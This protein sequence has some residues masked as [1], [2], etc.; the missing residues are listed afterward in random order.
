MLQT[1]KRRWATLLFGIYAT[2]Q[3]F[4]G[5]TSA[6]DSVGLTVASRVNAVKGQ[7]ATLSASYK[8]KRRLVTLMWGKVDGLPGGRERTVYMYSPGLGL[9]YALGPLEGRAELVGEASLKIR[10][11]KLSDEGAYYVSVI[12]DELGEER[13]YVN[14]NVLVQPKV[15]VGPANPY[16]VEWSKNVTLTCSTKDAKPPIKTLFWEKDG[17]RI[18]TTD[19]GK[20][21]RGNM[22]APFLIISNV[23]KNEAGRY[24]CV[25]DH[26]TGMHRAELMLKVIY[27][28]VITNITK[29]VTGDRISLHCFA[30]GNP[31]PE[32]T[33][34]KAKSYVPLDSRH[35]PDDD[36]ATHVLVNV[37]AND[38]GVYICTARNGYGVGE[39][40]SLRIVVAD[41][42]QKPWKHSPHVAIIAGVAAAVAW[43]IVCTVLVTCIVHRRRKRNT[44]AVPRYA[45]QLSYLEGKRKGASEH[46]RRYARVLYDYDPKDD[47]E[48]R[49]RSNDIIDIIRGDNEGWWF[50]YLNGRCGLFPSNYVE[51]ITVTEREAL[52]LGVPDIAISGC[53]EEVRASIRDKAN[54]EYYRSLPRRP[55]ERTEKPVCPAHPNRSRARGAPRHSGLSKC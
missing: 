13:K 27:P 5:L 15:S 46:E 33:W 26:V 38:S 14:L 30:D 22:R 21:S 4:I 6:Q 48:L 8:S 3:G 41:E 37:M 42:V 24:A 28:A 18:Q 45:L 34:T 50:G 51:V 40:R 54:K 39:S 12:L 29:S 47:D 36:M 44:A 52:R 10:E 7:P 31:K 35:F 32:I 25:V 55:K 53:N 11:T 43:V 23:S 9:Q 2:C 19:G 1:A 16:V 20:Y 49:L 17:V